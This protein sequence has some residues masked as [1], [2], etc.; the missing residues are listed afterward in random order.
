VVRYATVSDARFYY[1]HRTWN[2]AKKKTHVEFDGDALIHTHWQNDILCHSVSFVSEIAWAVLATA[3]ISAAQW[4]VAVATKF[5][6]GDT[7]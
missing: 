4:P 3:V 1:G 2:E 6:T 5:V 7:G